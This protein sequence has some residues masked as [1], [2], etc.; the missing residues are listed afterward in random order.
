MGD[1]V[2]LIKM[3]SLFSFDSAENVDF[4]TVWDSFKLDEISILDGVPIDL[5]SKSKN[6]YGQRFVAGYGYM[7]EGQKLSTHK[8][9]NA[10]EMFLTLEGDITEVVTG[11][12]LFAGRPYKIRKDLSHGFKANVDS[13]FYFIITEIR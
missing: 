9:P 7:R 13:K 2:A 5:I 3:R 11:T 6:Q 8:H 12:P 10:R 1:S 4:Q